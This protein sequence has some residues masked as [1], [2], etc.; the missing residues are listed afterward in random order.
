MLTSYI[1]AQ[2][3]MFSGILNIPTLI[4]FNKSILPRYKIFPLSAFL[5]KMSSLKP[6][7]TDIFNH[8]GC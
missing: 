7:K 3:C 6:I 5:T 2:V 4:S 8:S 1:L